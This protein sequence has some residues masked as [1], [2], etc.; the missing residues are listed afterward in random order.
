MPRVDFV[1]ET[2]LSQSTRARQLEAMFDVPPNE[3]AKLEWHGD[4]P[5]DARPWHVGLIVGPSGCGKSTILKGMFGEPST[6]TWGGAS[7]IDDFRDDLSMQDIAATCEA[8][9]FN[10]IPAWLRPY[11]V[12]SNGERFRVELAR[13]MLESEG[14]VV[15]DEFTSVVDRQV[16]KIGSHA[17]Q[18]IVRRAGRQ[19]VCASCHFDIV[20]W[21]QPDWV[22]EPA[23]MTFTWRELRRRPPLDIELRRVS[24]DTWNLF[25]PFHYLTSDLHRAAVCWALFIDERPVSFGGVLH[26]PHARSQNI[27]GL[28]RLVTLPDWQGLGLAMILCDAI[29]ARYRGAGF[30]FHTYPA[31]PSLIRSFD[32]SA[33]WRLEKKPGHYGPRRGDSSTVAWKASRPCAV[34]SYCGLPVVDDDFSAALA[35]S[36]RTASRRADT[37]SLPL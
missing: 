19:V 34:F 33:N 24:F 29:A 8:V 2:A 20:D 30:V 4:L 22:L 26:R 31:H 15:I 6:L 1:V 9:G 28:S 32:K 27:K 23:S 17:V 16:A 25:A 36:S 14:A 12:L 11:S 35:T 3:R 7:V 18:K 10:T 5:I 37:A 13:R 21:L